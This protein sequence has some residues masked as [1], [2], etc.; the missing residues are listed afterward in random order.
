MTQT[1]FGRGN[2]AL[3]ALSD[4]VKALFSIAFIGDPCPTNKTGIF[5]KGNLF[6]RKA[7]LFPQSHCLLSFR[8]AALS[9]EEPAFPPQLIET[10]QEAHRLAHPVNYLIIARRKRFADETALLQ[11]RFVGI[12]IKTKPQ[13]EKRPGELGG[14]RRE[15]IRRVDTT[16]RR[17]VECDIARRS[18]QVHIGDLP[19]LRDRKFDRELSLLHFGGFWNQAVPVVFHI[20]QNSL[21][22]RAEIHALG[23]AQNFEIPQRPAMRSAVQ[24]EV[25]LLT[26]AAS[27]TGGC[28]LRRLLDRRARAHPIRVFAEGVIRARRRLQLRRLIRFELRT[29]L[30]LPLLRL[31]SRRLVLGD[32]LLRR[33]RRARTAHPRS[34]RRR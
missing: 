14:Q 13:R 28:C 15:R 3:R 22:I 6:L 2:R 9:R 10:D 12:V 32:R 5:S 18:D 4:S 20:L 29:R 25:A 16:P 30:L 1:A 11:I 24:A 8:R 27:T 26:P 23:I 34:T 33:L 19:I 17:P 31:L 21:Q 7:L